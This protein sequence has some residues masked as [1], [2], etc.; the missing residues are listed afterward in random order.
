M[1]LKHFRKIVIV[2]LCILLFARVF[3]GEEAS[4]WKESYLFENMND[5]CR[6]EEVKRLS[7]EMKC[8][9]V[10]EKSEME[11]EN[12]YGG[13]RSYGGPRKHEGIDIIPKKEKDDTYRVCSVADGFVEKIGWL[14]LGGYRVG[15]RSESGFYYYY[16]HLAS[17]QKGLKEGSK[18]KAGDV[19]GRMGNTGYGKEGTKGKFIVHLH[20]GI[21]RQTD[22]E[23]KS[24]NPY[25]LLQYLEEGQRW[26]YSF[27][28]RY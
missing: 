19:I 9:P 28:E 22:G 26:R 4:L 3:V 20:F 16:A 21:Y 11:F 7:R 5:D 1:T 18:V 17:Y 24:L 6:M 10:R 13:E 15:I 14:E 12:G 27:G 25:Y 2:L 8:F 23:E